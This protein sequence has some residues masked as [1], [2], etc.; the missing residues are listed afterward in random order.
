MGDGAQARG[1]R[2]GRPISSAHTRNRGEVREASQ[3]LAR[4]HDIHRT[5]QT[6][7]RDHREHS[8]RHQVE[9]VALRCEQ[10]KTVEGW[11]CR[12]RNPLGCSPAG[13]TAT[14]SSCRS[15][16]ERRGER[17]RVQD[18]ER[19][20]LE[21]GGDVFHGFSIAHPVLILGHV[22]YVGHQKGIVQ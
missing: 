8:P 14:L 1:H 3:K 21:I 18:P 22:A 7:E 4:R 20:S 17:L 2:S 5:E 19:L 13:D 6:V 12:G 11:A 10:P 16:F 15:P 9:V